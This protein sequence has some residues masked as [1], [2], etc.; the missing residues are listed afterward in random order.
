MEETWRAAIASVAYELARHNGE[1]PMDRGVA[2]G[3]RIQEL[4][5]AWGLV[6]AFEVFKE[7][8]AYR[9]E[10]CG[11]ELYARV[12][13]LVYAAAPRTLMAA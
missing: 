1:S 7:E 4:A 2:L 3:E 9:G 12:E 10:E 11:E 6:G 13:A 5:R 8:R